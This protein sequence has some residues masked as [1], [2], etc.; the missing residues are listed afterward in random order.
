M[1]GIEPVATTS[2]KFDRASSITF[3]TDR[4]SLA[5]SVGPSDVAGSD[6]TASGTA[7]MAFIYLYITGVPRPGAFGEVRK[8]N[9]GNGGGLF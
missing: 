7:T 5:G 2:L 9:P 6:T 8:R 4:S 3:V 1:N